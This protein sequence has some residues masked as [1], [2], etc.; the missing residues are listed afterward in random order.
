MGYPAS[1]ITT[2]TFREPLWPKGIIGS[3]THSQTLALVVVAN[4]NKAFSGV[5]IDIE[6]KN[7][8]SSD[9]VRDLLTDRELTELRT[10]GAGWE[11][12]VTLIFSAKEAVFK[13]VNPITNLMIDFNELEI[14]VDPHDRSFRAKYGGPNEINRIMNR[15]VGSH[16]LFEDHFVTFFA[17][18][19]HSPS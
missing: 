6:T 5:G 2:G 12:D 7:G 14:Q 17:V 9:F 16:G 3:I 4:K 11:N 13:A 8:V 1:P 18:P 10:R 19:S 15:G